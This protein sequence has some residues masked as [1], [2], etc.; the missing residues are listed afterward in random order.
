MTKY[1]FLLKSLKKHGY[2]YEYIDIPNKLT[3]KDYIKVKYLDEIYKQRVNKHL[4][5]K[6]PEK[7]VIKKTTEQFIKESKEIWEDRFDYNNVVYKGSL[8][9]VRLY[10]KY[11]NKFIEQTASSHLK[12]FEPKGMDSDSF[13]KISKQISDFK[14]DYSKCN[15]INKSTKVTLICKEHGEFEVLP[16]NH[17]NYGEVCKKCLFTKFSKS[18]KKVLESRKISHYTQHKF[19]KFELLFDFYIPSL[20]L[21]IDFT[22][23]NNLTKNN[24]ILKESYCEDNYINIIVIPYN[25]IDYIENII[26]NSLIK[27]P[28]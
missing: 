18:V 5:G 16:F 12:G 9:K 28:L 26:K 3:L 19:E 2:K 6:C 17:I 13:I 10:D 8:K 11:E 20:R 15:Y 21:C 7:G 1:E 24:D 27:K 14:Y 25:K 4:M 22:Y 23:K